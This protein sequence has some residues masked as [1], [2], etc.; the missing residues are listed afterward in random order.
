M[1]DLRIYPDDYGHIEK[2]LATPQDILVSELNNEL[3]PRS[4]I[5]VLL[6][7]IKFL[8]QVLSTSGSQPRLNPEYGVENSRVSRCLV[9]LQRKL[10]K[11]GA[12]NRKLQLELQKADSTTQQVI[13]I[14]NAINEV[15]P[16]LEYHLNLL[17]LAALVVVIGISRFFEDLDF[18]QK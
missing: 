7:T 15:N 5:D 12:L 8:K 13:T 18:D 3:I 17:K 1:S 16:S 10:Q 4:Q 6:S 9:D 14:A 2:Y 11:Q